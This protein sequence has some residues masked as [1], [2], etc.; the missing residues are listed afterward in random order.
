MDNIITNK[1][2]NTPKNQTKYGINLYK[3][4][5]QIAKQQ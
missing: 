3:T 5:N 1:K 2:K 4:N